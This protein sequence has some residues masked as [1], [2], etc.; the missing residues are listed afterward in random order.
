MTIARRLAVFYATESTVLRRKVIPDSDVELD[1]LH[2]SPG[3]SMLL[4]PL[5]MPHDDASCRA[6][7]ASATGVSPPSGRC[8]V[9]NESGVVIAVCNADPA[10]DTHSAG[11]MVGSEIARPGDR[12]V[13]GMFLRHYRVKP[14]SSGAVSSKAWL[15]VSEPPLSKANFL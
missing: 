8:C 7:I 6:A 5:N 2:L 13:D 12:Y 4:L 9:I 15:P 3:E 11:P 14:A 10:L 1:G